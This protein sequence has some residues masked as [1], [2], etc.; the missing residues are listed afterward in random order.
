M[1]VAVV[2]VVLV[3]AAIGSFSIVAME[4]GEIKRLV[5]LKESTG[6]EIKENEKKI[7]DLKE[8]ISRLISEKLSAEDES[9]KASN[10][11]EGFKRKAKTLQ[12]QKLWN[13]VFLFDA[14]VTHT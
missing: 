2:G 4:L 10:E 3:V 14:V 6:R 9:S 5:G 13:Q 11:T 12:D 7:S 1:A 8:E